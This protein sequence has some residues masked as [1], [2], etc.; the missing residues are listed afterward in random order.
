MFCSSLF[1]K[2]N[3]FVACFII[4]LYLF[5]AYNSLGDTCAPGLCSSDSNTVC[6]NKVCICDVANGFTVIEGDRCGKHNFTLPLMKLLLLL[7]QVY[8]APPPLPTLII[9]F[10]YVPLHGCNMRFFVVVFSH[11]VILS[12]TI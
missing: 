10:S 6:V 2:R 5:S 3:L 4:R 1:Y 11:N 12:V 7:V 8:Q 9:N